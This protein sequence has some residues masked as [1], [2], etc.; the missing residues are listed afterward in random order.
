[1]SP[2]RVQEPRGARVS[3]DYLIFTPDDV[4]LARSPLRRSIDEP[5]FV[6]GAFNP[7]LTRLPNGNLLL[8]VRVAEA[9]AR[10]G[11]TAIARARSAGRPTAMCSTGIRLPAS[12]WTIRASSRSGTRYP[13]LLGLTSLSWL[14]PVELTPRRAQHRQGPLRQGDRALGLASSNMASRMRGSAWSAA[15]GG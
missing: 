10:A 15:A 12:R 3:D 14:L 1:M 9:L 6:L 7:G 2:V 11:L 8:M 5:T 13:R 4:D